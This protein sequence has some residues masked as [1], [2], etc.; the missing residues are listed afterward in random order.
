[1]AHNRTLQKSFYSDGKAISVAST[2]RLESLEK[3]LKLVAAAEGKKAG[4]VMADALEAYL[5]AKW[6]EIMKS[7]SEDKNG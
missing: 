7:Y 6:A 2:S 1:M 5:P 3:K 4:D